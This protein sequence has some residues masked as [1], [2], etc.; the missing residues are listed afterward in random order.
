[1]RRK[2]EEEQRAAEYRV[3]Q[4]LDQLPVAVFVVDSEGRAFYENKRCKILLGRKLNPNIGMRNLSQYYKVFVAGSEEFYPVLQLPIVR[5]LKGESNEK[6]DLEIE[7]DGERT[8]VRMFGAPIYDLNNNI[9]Y[10]ISVIDDLSERSKKESIIS[11]Q[12][13]LIVDG[14]NYGLKVQNALLPDSKQ[15]KQMFPD[16][17]V[18][19]RAKHIV[20]GDFPLVI[21]SGHNTY[22]GAVD[23]TGHG[24]PGALM[25][26]AGYNLINDIILK[27]GVEEPG[28]ILQHLHLSM[29]K[30]MNHS[31]QGYHVGD[32]MDI[33]L[34]RINKAEGF[35]E[36]AGARNPLYIGYSDSFEIIH[37]EDF[38][39]AEDLIRHRNNR[40]PKFTNHKIE[41][42]EGMV[43]YMASDGYKDQFG[44]DS[45]KKFD[46]KRLREML[47]D[48]SNLTM[49]K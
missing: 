4:F 7:H 16:S 26:I 38:S 6:S 8:S 22:V 37:A 27:G 36:Y 34:C 3:R 46:A 1:E 47:Y 42:R 35:V 33:A 40:K 2:N 29:K 48:N 39:I 44:G 20:S 32:G 13:K 21:Q 45:K 28:L 43:L 5:A 30:T 11:R 9:S 18:Y 25:S 41:Y 15:L 23:C 24:V 31:D 14:L 49:P 17:F 19:L 10:A 12:N